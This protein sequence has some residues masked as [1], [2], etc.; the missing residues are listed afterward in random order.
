MLMQRPHPLTS[1]R[2]QLPLS[3]AV[4]A[5]VAALALSTVLINLLRQHY[6]QQELDLLSRTANTLDNILSRRIT[7]PITTET[8]PLEIQDLSAFLD[9]RIETLSPQMTLVSDTGIPQTYTITVGALAA[10]DINIV[11]ALPMPNEFRRRPSLVISSGEFV[12]MPTGLPSDA[13]FGIAGG[14]NEIQAVMGE[15]FDPSPF[16]SV[17][18]AQPTW[19][20]NT[21]SL[22]DYRFSQP[23]SSFY[24]APV[25][26]SFD[27]GS[28][29]WVDARQRSDQEIV[30]AIGS[31]PQQ[32]PL[33]YLRISALPA[34]GTEIVN[35][36][37]MAAIIAGIA[38]V[39][40]A[41]GAGYIISRRLTAPLS[42][43][44]KA[45]HNMAAG[46]YWVRADVQRSDELGK[47]ANAFNGMAHQVESTVTALRR[48]VADAAHELHT[49][50]TALR[51]DLELA[52]EQP[53]VAQVGAALKQVSRLETLCDDLLD[54]SRLESP[55][56]FWQTAHTPVNMGEIIQ[57]LG[58]IYASRAEQR[59]IDF[60][61]E[62]EPI[63]PP[64]PAG[65]PTQIRRALGNLLDNAL[66][67]TPSGGIV[68]LTA[69]RS[70]TCLNIRVIDSGIG[71]P[72]AE[73]DRIFDHF[74][75]GSNTHDYPG[76]GLGLA[77]TNAIIKAHGG[78]INVNS[79]IGR[80]KFDIGLPT[81]EVTKP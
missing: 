59:D 10:T 17:Q 78:S 46:E 1:I 11:P 52:R 35:S 32:T 7:Q 55:A 49:P 2:W 20:E 4:I 24:P 25:Q 54:L 70:N 68:T 36:V 42:Q 23:A 62:V 60:S 76:S 13:T 41:G 44:E 38:S 30:I 61:F 64:L 67:F 31:A 33:G 74:Y 47:L 69:Q 27:S 72:S 81:A 43:L 39:I 21:F 66:K 48:F 45:A 28:V 71:I 29:S 26:V 8:V 65:N 51:T 56:L 80:T 12:A 18:E 37:A 40:L 19:G 77:I 15:T 50:L 57:E 22:P 3:Y 34:I 14:R 75:R 6:S 53:S 16:A 79:D 63:L 5:L 9:V 58:E 73:L